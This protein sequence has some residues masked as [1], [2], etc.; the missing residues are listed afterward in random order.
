MPAE[1]VRRQLNIPNGFYTIMITMGGVPNRYDYVRN[2]EKYHQ[3][4]FIIPGASRRVIIQN[5]LRLLPHYS[6]FYHP[7]LI[8]AS[9]AV[10]GKAGYSTIAEIYYAGIPFGYIS[11][12]AFRESAK[13]TDF[14]KKNMSGISILEAELHN[15]RWM[16]KIPDIMALPGFKPN[17][18]N[19]ADQIADFIFNLPQ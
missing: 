18:T 12:P 10:I 2:L 4:Y 5:N 7:D 11:R 15:G 8:N 14:I 17:T 19:G 6:E 13:L 1:L 9:D 3:L 16:D